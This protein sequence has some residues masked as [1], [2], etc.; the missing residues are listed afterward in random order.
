MWEYQVSLKP[1][2][3]KKIIRTLW[4]KR[5]NNMSLDDVNESIDQELTNN[6]RKKLID[7]YQL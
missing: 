6:I 4:Q 2:Q 7:D 3:F 5:K 1:N